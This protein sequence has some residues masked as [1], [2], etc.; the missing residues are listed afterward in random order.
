MRG[1]LDITGPLDLELSAR[2]L[3]APPRAGRAWHA[4]GDYWHGHEYRR[5]VW[6]TGQPALLRLFNRGSIDHPDVGWRL[7]G[8]TG[9]VTGGAGERAAIAHRVR[10]LI[11]AD[12]DLA[13]CYASFRS[14]P[15]LGPLSERFC[16]LRILRFPSLYECLVATILEQ[17]LNFWFAAQVKRQLFTAH[18]P[19]IV[20]EGRHYIGVPAPARLAE[21][22]PE[23]LRP[24]QI[25]APKARAL[26]AVAAAARDGRLDPPPD[27]DA[28]DAEAVAEHLMRLRGVGRWS[29]TYARLRGLGHT[30][31]LPSDDVGLLRSV[32]HLYSARSPVT[33]Q[34]LQRRW[35]KLAPWRG[36]ATYYV[37]L[38]QWLG[39]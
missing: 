12:T 24:L 8:V 5:I 36:Y 34:G 26:A 7:E 20:F 22:T 28:H 18:G 4:T 11:S 9:G 27:P 2:L 39:E 10:H 3:C 21:L 23:A 1:R 32:T 33:P 31:A 6:W 14:D 16:G 30:D 35:K 25:S 29:A 17:Q 19:E 15:V 13:A 38:T 37:W